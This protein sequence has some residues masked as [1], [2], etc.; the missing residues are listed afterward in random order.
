MGSPD[1]TMAEPDAAGRSTD[2]SGKTARP[3]DR[4]AA[5]PLG[6][7]SSEG[8]G[9]EDAGTA[10]PPPMAAEASIRIGT[11][12]VL[13]PL[14]GHMAT[15]AAGQEDIGFYGTDLGRSAAYKGV[16]RLMFGDTSRSPGTEIDATYDDVQGDISLVDFPNGPAVD[17]YV[18]AHPPKPGQLA[19]QAAGPPVRFLTRDGRI[20]ASIPYRD[21]QPLAMSLGRTPVAVWTDGGEGLFAIFNRIA[22]LACAAKQP[23]CPNGF[24]CDEGLGAGFGV[25]ME[26]AMPCVIAS[27]LGC[28]AVPSGGY[29]QDPTSST[30]D[31]SNPSA[32]K[33][34]VV[35]QEELGNED[36]TEPGHYRTTAFITNKFINSCGRT[37]ADFDPGRKN[38]AG[39]V[40][41]AAIG[42]GER[43]KLLLW[44][45]P[46]FSG[47]RGRDARL[48]LQVLDLPQYEPTGRFDLQP[49]Y[50][51]HLEA[52]VPQFS[53][54]EIDAKPLD[55]SYASGDPTTEAKDVVGELDITWIAPLQKW[56]MLYG[57]HY[58]PGGLLAM[59]G[60]GADEVVPDPEGA[61]SIRFADQPWGPWSAPE[62]L[63]RAQA[64]DG[65]AVPLPAAPKGILARV[66]CSGADCPPVEP[67]YPSS[68]PGQFYSAHLIEPWTTARGD[69]VDVYWVVS[70]WNP[71][72][73]VLMKSELH[74]SP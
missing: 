58:S 59:Q 44:G 26:G 61:V 66:D 1:A 34:S 7:G 30:Y 2:R 40:Y 48:Y 68:E 38:G 19:W 18:G 74:K 65:A 32:R 53:D 10:E 54:R 62:P 3:N 12:T 47:A 39:N 50:F 22:P 8:A 52:G 24:V 72:Q 13:A 11:T 37:V 9:S 27:D 31:A 63:L 17:A 41:T 42:T 51:T 45:R 71:Y 43:E 57:G 4:D 14:V 36:L 6:P 25:P 46:W 16:L 49:R 5:L 21:G 69:S 67:N 55:L 56:L 23:R 29:C 33:M 73:V 64:K 70:T 28:A 15:P 35:Y 20:G 60:T